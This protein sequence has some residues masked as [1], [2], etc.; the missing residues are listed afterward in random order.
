MPRDNN[1]GITYFKR[2][3]MEFD[4]ARPLP[5]APPLAPAYS[6]LDWNDDLIHAHAD[7]LYRSFR[8]EIDANVFPNLGNRDGC[9]RLMSEISQRSNFLSEATWL[10]QY[11]PQRGRKPESVG[12]IQGVA[13]DMGLGA[14]QNVGVIE[15][16]RGRG[17][18]TAL[19][20]ASLAGFRA[21][22]MSRVFLEVTAQNDGAVRLYQRI[23][24]CK[25]KTV[26]K[27]VEVPEVAYA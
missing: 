23:G 4:L 5:A 22:G 24:F 9:K 18:G 25:T 10:V 26:Y 2:W 21:A 13:D 16:H 12:T 27:A 7:A 3:R 8:F 1:M 6:L 11:W 15:S 19:L 14:I 20:A 17:I